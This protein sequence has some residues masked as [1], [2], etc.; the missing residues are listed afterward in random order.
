MIPKGFVFGG[1]AANN[2]LI[3]RS[4]TSLSRR[5]SQS[6]AVSKVLAR[7]GVIFSRTLIMPF[8]TLFLRNEI[9][10]EICWSV[11]SESRWSQYNGNPQPV[12]RIGHRELGTRIGHKRSKEGLEGKQSNTKLTEKARDLERVYGEIDRGPKS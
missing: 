10:A 1:K 9:L 2:S 4:C 11:T 12:K 8:A 5:I 3:F 6:F 7:E